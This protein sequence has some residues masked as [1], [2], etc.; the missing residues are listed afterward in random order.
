MNKLFE[1]F[2]TKTPNYYSEHESL[3]DNFAAKGG[4]ERDKR[5][6]KG[7]HFSTFYEF[8]T[9]CFFLGLYNK[10]FQEIPSGKKKNFSMP[11]SSWGTKKG[12]GREDFSKL[13][14]NIF[15][16]LITKVDIDY[17]ALDKGE[18]SIDD[19]VKDLINNLESITNGGIY[20][21]K[22]KHEENPNYFFGE[23]SF[24]YFIGK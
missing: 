23:T 13:Q 7:K 4:A 8:Y 17:V 10:E 24:L 22:E 1:N 2:K 19:V 11:I 16:A 15:I 5:E 18:I 6:T 21:V 20:L 9:Y 14:E 3:F 12:T